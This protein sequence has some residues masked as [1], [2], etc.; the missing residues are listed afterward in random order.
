MKFSKLI[1]ALAVFCLFLISLYFYSSP[2]GPNSLSSGQKVSPLSSMHAPGTSSDESAPPS[3]ESMHSN[4]KRPFTS[5]SAVA[6][7][8]FHQA[9]ALLINEA[10]AEETSPLKDPRFQILLNP[11]AGDMMELYS[12]T[13]NDPAKLKSLT[14][15]AKQTVNTLEQCLKEDT[16]CGQESE[17]EATGNNDP[18]FNPDQTPYHLALSNALQVLELSESPLISFEEAVNFLNWENENIVTPAMQIAIHKI[19]SLPSSSVQESFS[20]L[21]RAGA[22]LKDESAKSFIKLTESISGDLK[23]RTLWKAEV[24]KLISTLDQ[25]TVIRIAQGLA[26]TKITEEEFRELKHKFCERIRLKGFSVPAK[27]QIRLNLTKIS[28]AKGFSGTDTETCL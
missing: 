5:Y 16:L 18:Y 15:F 9:G 4:D 3:S 13:K 28:E 14:E 10:K 7:N 11:P 19:E 26:D 21:M 6:Q 23:K 17:V 2:L 27:K 22:Q 12:Q 24:S 25:S 20:T 8:A 1:T